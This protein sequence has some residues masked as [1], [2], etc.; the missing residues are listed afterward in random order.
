MTFRPIYIWLSQAFG[1]VLNG[2]ARPLTGSVL[3][4]FGGCCPLNPS[5][6]SSPGRWCPFSTVYARM[7]PSF[8]DFMALAGR[9]YDYPNGC[10]RPSF[11][12][13]M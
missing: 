11:A 5:L 7:W 1:P 10:C 2:T 3:C 12:F 9:V 8:Y 6:Y 13:D 4:F